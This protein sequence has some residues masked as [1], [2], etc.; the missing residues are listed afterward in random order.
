VAGFR[1]VAAY[2]PQR[3]TALGLGIVSAV[4]A[5]RPGLP[6]FELAVCTPGAVPLRTD[7][8]LSLHVEHGLDAL[9]TAD[10]VLVLPGEDF[11]TGP[12]AEV[13]DALRAANARGAV[14]AGHCV[15]VFVLAAAG[16]LDG[17]EAT[18]H[19]QFAGELAARYPAV[20]VRPEA[21][22][23]DQG[24]VVTGAGAAA[25]IDLCL[26]LVRRE[27]GTAVTNTI[28]RGLV[29][30]PHREGGQT[31]YIETPVPAD[32]GDRLLFDTIA[33]ARMNLDRRI[34][35]DELAAR[36][37]TSRR[38]YIRRFKAATGTTPH[39]WLLAQRLNRAEDLLE[40]TNLSVEEVA[41]QVG[42]RSAAMLRE[43]FTLRRGVAPSAYRRTF[44]SAPQLKA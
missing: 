16:L 20:T 19:W 10:L 9:A 29:I 15:G 24:D 25:G 22:Y 36:A 42:Y 12:S 14:V 17:R 34:T 5:S 18:T 11:R 44:R 6:A 1:R 38:S 40:T 23:V 41:R 28:A 33:W 43:Q 4:F 31:Q 39:A 26:H 21:L 37:V 27:H 35:V 13:L 3:A 2:A 7:L 30:P 32:G 8:G